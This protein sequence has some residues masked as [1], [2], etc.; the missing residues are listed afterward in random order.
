MKLHS[1]ETRNRILNSVMTLILQGG[2]QAV[3]LSRVCQLSKLSKGG[4]VHYFPS[5]EALIETFIQR[6]AERYLEM[7]QTT[8]AGIPEGGGKRALKYVAEFITDQ[9]LTPD[10]NRDCVAVMVALIQS[11]QQSADFRASHDSILNRLRKDGISKE[12]ATTILVTVDGFWFQSVIENAQEMGNRAR[13]I[14]RQ[15]NRL[16]R[17]ELKNKR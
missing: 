17:D 15:L 8:L 12:L 10:A 1:A 6:A 13:L 14:R 5:K 9:K 16:I 3:T 11:G 4:L 7:V 2:V